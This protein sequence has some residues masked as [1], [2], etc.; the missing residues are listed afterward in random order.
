MPQ[1]K[2]NQL[3]AT[4]WLAGLST[5]ALVGAVAAAWMGGC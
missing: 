5:G 4:I 1:T 3:L 2:L